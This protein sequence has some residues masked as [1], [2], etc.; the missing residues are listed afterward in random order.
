MRGLRNFLYKFGIWFAKI[1]MAMEFIQKLMVG[2][3]LS[4]CHGW[5]E[6]KFLI[7]HADFDKY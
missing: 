2:Y 4:G 6:I 3:F 1:L 5:K 7:L